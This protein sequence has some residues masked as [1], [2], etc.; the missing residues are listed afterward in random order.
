MITGYLLLSYLF[1]HPASQPAASLDN[2]A[3]CL[4][5]IGDC[6]YL[7]SSTDVWRSL[8]SYVKASLPS[9]ITRLGFVAPHWEHP[10]ETHERLHTGYFF[11]LTNLSQTTDSS[12]YV[13]GKNYFA[14]SQITD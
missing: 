13:R 3:A 12:A 10:K 8:G 9:H 7:Q 2:P 6:I 4:L 1:R 11:R 5:S 14:S